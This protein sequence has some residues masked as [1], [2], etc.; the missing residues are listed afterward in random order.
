MQWG[1]ARKYFGLGIGTRDL[2]MAL[3][4][5]SEKQLNDGNRIPVLGLGTWRDSGKAVLFALKHGLRL[6]DTAALYG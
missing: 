4:L 5:K 1:G 2:K 3:T 6:I